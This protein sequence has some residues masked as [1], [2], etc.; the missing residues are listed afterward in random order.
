M[1]ETTEKSALLEQLAHAEFWALTCFAQHDFA[2]AAEFA[3]IWCA[4]RGMLDGGN[5]WPS[6]YQGKS[7]FAFLATAASERLTTLNPEGE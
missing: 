7:P 3:A 4:L 1:S 2:T 5:T 6:G